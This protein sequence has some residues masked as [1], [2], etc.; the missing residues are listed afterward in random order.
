MHCLNPEYDYAVILPPYNTVWAQVIKRD[1]PP[2]IITQGIQVAYRILG[3]T[4]SYSKKKFGGFWDNAEVLFGAVI[5]TSQ[6]LTGHG[7]Q[8]LMDAAGDHFVVTGIPLT[9]YKDDGIW[10]PYQEGEIT[11]KDGQGTVLIQ[12]HVMVPTSDEIHCDLCHV[13]SAENNNNPFLDILQKH[14]KLHTP[15]DGFLVPMAPVLCASCH[16]SP[17]LGTVGPGDAGIYLSQAV[18][19]AH[20]TRTAPDGS[21]IACYNCHPGEVTQCSRSLRHTRTDGNC[22]TCHGDML[23]VASTIADGRIPW[24]TEPKC[25]T[26]HSGVAEV[27]TD[28]ILYRNSTGHGSMYCPSCHNSP[29]AM[30]QSSEA[31]DNYQALQYLTASTK[32]KSIGSCGPCHSSSRGPSEI[33]SYAETHGG[34]NPSNANG[35][36]IC[37][38]NVRTD[39]VQWPHAFQWVNSN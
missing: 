35:C 26:C 27:D 34:L 18:H 10:T 14:D 5:D 28:T 1:D 16:G 2:Q 11:V 12:T 19:H 7:L 31:T 9:P 23:N 30:I 32:V 25:V 3:N 21:P 6:G 37:H 22:T 8:G 29:H 33:G 17:A 13:P 20:A 4:Y 24:A 36:N 39:M 38:T 15:P